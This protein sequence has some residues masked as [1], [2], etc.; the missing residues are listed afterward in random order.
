MGSIHNVFIFSG[1]KGKRMG[2]F[3]KNN[4]KAFAKVNSKKLLITHIENV[5]KFLNVEKIFVI[6][7]EKK[8]FLKIN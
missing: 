2:I 8:V 3:K 4:V 5:N 1:G 7:T 6:I